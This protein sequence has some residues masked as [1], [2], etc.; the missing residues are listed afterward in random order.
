MCVYVN[1]CVFGMHLRWG[2]S[3]NVHLCLYVF[4]IYLWGIDVWY[5]ILCVCM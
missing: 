2:G 4:I 1:V 5:L 3:L